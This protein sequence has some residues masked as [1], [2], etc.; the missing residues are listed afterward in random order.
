L[1]ARNAGALDLRVTAKAKIR[2]PLGQQFGVDGS[3]HAVAHRAALAQRRMFEDK[4]AGL[5]AVT[6]ATRFIGPRQKEAAGRLEGVA[7][8]GVVALD[9]IHLLLEDRVMLGQMKLSFHRAMAFKTG[10]GIFARVDDEF[11]TAAA[12]GD[13]QTAR[14]VTGLAAG[15]ARRAGV[16]EANAGVRTG[17]ENAGDISMAL[18]AGTVAHKTGTRYF[19]RRGKGNRGAGAG[20]EQDGA[21]R[22]EG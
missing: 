14:A 7:A 17:G 10:V 21:G 4:R 19:R 20:V 3:M 12:T 13:V 5:F 16:G 15:L 1:A 9:T 2:I 18:G 22:K 8:M 6:L 11:S